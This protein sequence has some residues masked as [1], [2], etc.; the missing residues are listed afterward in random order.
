MASMF[1]LNLGIYGGSIAQ[2]LAYLITDPTTLG[3]IPIIPQK[4]SEETIVQVE[5][6]VWHCLEESGQWLENIDQTHQVVAS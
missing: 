4:N 6:N 1:L 2:W 5:V 3:S